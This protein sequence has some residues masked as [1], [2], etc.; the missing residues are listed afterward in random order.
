[1]YNLLLFNK[2]H[3]KYSLENIKNIPE[4]NSCAAAWKRKQ[5]I[6]ITLNI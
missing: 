1:M 4:I 6:R 3:S 2:L 5:L